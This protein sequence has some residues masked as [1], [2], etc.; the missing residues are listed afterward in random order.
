MRSSQLFYKKF[1]I[2]RSDI[3]SSRDVL[4]LGGGSVSHSRNASCGNDG[5][6]EIVRFGHDGAGSVLEPESGLV[7]DLQMS[8]VLSIYKVCPFYGVT[9]NESKG[10]RRSRTLP[11][12]KD[13]GLVVRWSF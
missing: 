7:K 6:T 10:R 5:T 4:H 9:S 11:R 1:Y 2:E 13:L 8:R 12:H 3:V